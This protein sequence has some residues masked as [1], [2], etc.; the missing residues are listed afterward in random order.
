MRQD[1][2]TAGLNRAKA[3]FEE[4]RGIRFFVRIAIDPNSFV[5]KDME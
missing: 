4:R 1:E 5:C 3:Y 2:W